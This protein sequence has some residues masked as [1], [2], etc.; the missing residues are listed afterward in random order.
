VTPLAIAKQ[1]GISSLLAAALVAQAASPARADHPDGPRPVAGP[2]LVVVL[3]H[4]QT[5]ADFLVRLRPHFGAGGFVRLV[6][7][8]ARFTECHIPYVPTTT[9]PGHA[10]LGTGAAPRGH[11]IVGNSWYERAESALVACDEDRA[12]RPVPADAAR[13]GSPRRLRA[14]TVGDVL[15]GAT[16]GAARV[17]GISEKPRAAILPAGHRA[18][19]AYWLDDRTGLMQTSSYYMEGLPAWAATANAARHPERAAAAPWTPLLP[20]RAYRGTEGGAVGGGPAFAHALRGPGAPRGTPGLNAITQS[21]WALE[22]LYDFARAAVVGEGLGAD[23]APDLLVLSVSV[24]DRVGHLFGPRSPEILDLMVRADRELARFLDFLDARTGGRYTVVLTAD[25][26][27]GDMSAPGRERASVSGDPAGAVSD[28]AFRAWVDGAVREAFGLGAAPSGAA[29]SFLAGQGD[30]TLWL[31]PA[32]LAAAGLTPAQAA[33][34]LTDPLRAAPWLAVARTP[35]QLEQGGALSAVEERLRRGCHPGRSGDLMWALRPYCYP[36][37]GDAHGEHGSP[38]PYDTHVPLVFYGWGVRPG[39]YRAP[40]ATSDIAPTV[41]AIL[42]IDA[43][44]QCEG[45]A[46]I[47]GLRLPAWR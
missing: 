15:R 20:P 32:A 36:G 19:A 11:G 30:A 21:P 6:D 34:A 9:G 27:A 5:H 47:E 4:D 37:G 17:V 1:L 46:L 13:G 7:G 12:A 41:A 8:G 28:S 10:T 43:P 42:G 16:L 31:D 24:T 38:Y 23:E 39:A 2:R 33:A 29:A 44:A 26:A 40:V 3:V 14:Q 18:T 35:E 45:R 22:R 25:H